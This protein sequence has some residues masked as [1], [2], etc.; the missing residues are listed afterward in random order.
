MRHY[1]GRPSNDPFFLQRTRKRSRNCVDTAY[2]ST[3]FVDRALCKCPAIT[4]LL[5]T[6][7]RVEIT[8]W[9]CF[10]ARRRFHRSFNPLRKARCEGRNARGC[11][12]RRRR[13]R[14]LVSLSPRLHARIRR[15]S[16]TRIARQLD[17]VR[18]Y[19]KFVGRL[20]GPS[21]ALVGRI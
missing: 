11:R 16:D 12:P 20:C 21:S 9:R 1:I 10:A 15:D 17:R 19:L 4:K 8:R 6:Q 2:K 7:K 18:L 5:I 14:C 3:L 13:R